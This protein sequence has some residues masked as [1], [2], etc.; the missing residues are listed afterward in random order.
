MGKSGREHRNK[1]NH[2]Q[3]AR[4]KKDA[5]KHLMFKREECSPK[6]ETQAKAG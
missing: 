2:R 5:I 1:Y 4:Y 3:E 6:N